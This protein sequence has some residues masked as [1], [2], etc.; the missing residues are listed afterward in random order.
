MSTANKY[1]LIIVG[2]LL[3][4]SFITGSVLLTIKLRQHQ[5]VEIS[6]SESA[7][8]ERTGQIYVDGAVTCPGFYA[9]NQGDTI[10][11]LVLAA[12]VS[13]DADWNHIKLY[14][15]RAGETR[16]T[17]KVNLNLAE[18]WLISALPGIGPETAQAIVDYRNQHGPFRRIE[19]LLRVKGIGTT[20][21]NRIRGLVTLEE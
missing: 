11:S 9:F 21:L 8:L 6:I 14:I 4:A 15:P 12:G 18:A 2:I 7:V 3:L 13:P 20:T 10:E 17:Q 5:P 1:W 19:E 16:Q